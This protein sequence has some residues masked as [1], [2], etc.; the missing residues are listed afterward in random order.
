MVCRELNFFAWGSTCVDHGV[1]YLSDCAESNLS[2][3]QDLPEVEVLRCRRAAR[4]CPDRRGQQRWRVAVVFEGAGGKDALD[5]L[6][7]P[8]KRGLR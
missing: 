8:R 5:R 3:V 4:K 6:Y 1:D 7:T 2:N